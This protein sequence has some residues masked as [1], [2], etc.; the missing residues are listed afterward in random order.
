LHLIADVRKVSPVN[1]PSIE[2][3]PFVPKFVSKSPLDKYFVI[4]KPR[5]VFGA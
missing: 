4:K 1:V 3:T 5:S 2:I